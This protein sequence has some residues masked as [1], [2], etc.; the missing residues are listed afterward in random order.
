MLLCSTAHITLFKWSQSV[1]T[2]LMY[3][4]KQKNLLFK[5]STC[6]PGH[7]FSVLKQISIVLI[8]KWSCVENVPSASKSHGGSHIFESLK[9]EPKVCIFNF[10]LS[11]SSFL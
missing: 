11:L 10:T 7:T 5:R 9:K 1:V 2:V 6:A 3:S 8:L 4:M